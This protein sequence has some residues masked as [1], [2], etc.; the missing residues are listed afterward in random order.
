MEVKLKK[1]AK[2]KQFNEKI[3]QVIE[4]RQ[5]EHERLKEIQNVALSL[6]DNIKAL[7]SGNI[8][9]INS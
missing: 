8:K 6:H 9:K 2:S 5:K 7:A 1:I 3:Q 4:Q